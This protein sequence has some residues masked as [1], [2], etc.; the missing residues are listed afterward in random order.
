MTT[1]IELVTGKVVGRVVTSGST[2]LKIMDTHQST[3][4]ALN[5]QYKI[6]YILLSIRWY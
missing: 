6:M 2:D 1:R 4:L 5:M 3:K